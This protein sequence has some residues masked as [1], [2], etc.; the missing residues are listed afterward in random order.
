[1]EN[2]GLSVYPNLD[3]AQGQRRFERGQQ[4]VAAIG[5]GVDFTLQLSS[6]LCQKL[7]QL[8]GALGLPPRLRLG[9][10]RLFLG[11]LKLGAADFLLLLLFPIIQGRIR[12][13]S[14]ETRTGYRPSN[15]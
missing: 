1:M 2:A 11:G 12:L 4:A 15:R 6:R 9:G 5:T 7:A 3:A 13:A 10:F 8:V 14:A